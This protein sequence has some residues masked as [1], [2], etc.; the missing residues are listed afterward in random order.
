MKKLL[1]F[2]AVLM[3]S[4]TIISCG[5]KDPLTVWV[6]SESVDFYTQKLEDYKAVYL[7]KYGE[8]FPHEFKVV[9]VDTGAA[10]GTFLNDTEAGA[11]I[12]TAAHDNLAKLTAGSSAVEA[13][14]SQELI[15]Q[16]NADNPQI[17]LDVI[18]SDVQ[19]TQY[20]FAVPYIAQSMILYYNTKY[21]TEDDVKTWEGILA[22]AEEAE[23]RALSISGTDGFNNSFILLAREVETKATTLEL[24]TNGVLENVNATGDD[25]IAK[26][27]W[28]QYF[29]TH[30]NGGLKPT[31]ATWSGELKN[32]TTISFVGGA[33]QYKSA[34]AA[35]GDNL[36]I[37]ILPT[38]TIG[39]DQAYG[40]CEA[41]TEF[42]SGS[43]FD[44][45]AFFMKK[46]SEYSKYLEDIILY[47]SSKEV[48][49]ESFEAAQNLPAYKNAQDEFEAFQEDTIEAELALTQLMM[50]EHSIPQP[51]GVKREFNVYYYQKGAP[52]L[53]F[54]IFE[55]L[56]DAYTTDEAIIAQMEIVE[57]IWE[58]GVN[59]KT[60]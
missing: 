45:K 58:T 30:P 29:F 15:N 7:E 57:E 47:L 24:Y 33:W 4:L 11:D 50:A 52:E 23:K 16:I 55:N 21:L 17:F 25:T 28:G 44:A 40:T 37:A 2:L 36:G 39:E 53:I 9:G 31:S 34:A 49:E 10:A 46:G 35:L 54:E 27:K 14:R 51:F 42:Q 32:E 6:G 13:V 60:S 56:D 12:F 59:N 3:I 19:G 20:I 1:M 22:K 41:G 48:Q 38:F 43:F 26:M 5:A 18:K 8:E